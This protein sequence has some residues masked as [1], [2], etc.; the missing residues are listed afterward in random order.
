MANPDASRNAAHRRYARAAE[1]ASAAGANTQG[2]LNEAYKQLYIN[3]DWTPE[4]GWAS[5]YQEGPVASITDASRQYM[6]PEYQEVYQPAPEPVIHVQ[7]KPTVYQPMQGES[8]YDLQV[9]APRILV[10]K[11][12]IPDLEAPNASLTPDQEEDKVNLTAADQKSVVVDES[13]RTPLEQAMLDNGTILENNRSLNPSVD[14]LNELRQQA[15]EIGDNY[16]GS[17]E[18]LANIQR[19]YQEWQND[20]DERLKQNNLPAGLEAEIQRRMT[21]MEDGSELT[22]PLDWNLLGFTSQQQTPSAVRDLYDFY[23]RQE[24]QARGTEQPSFT[25]G[26]AMRA[27][28]W[29]RNIPNESIRNAVKDFYNKPVVDENAIDDGRSPNSREA[30]MMTGDQYLKYRE[31]FGLPG[32]DVDEISPNELYNKQTEQ[33]QYGFIPYLTSEES[34]NR[35]HDAA[36]PMAVSNIFNNLADLR[37]ANTDF[38][39]DYN[40]EQYSGKDFAKNV[41][42]WDQRNSGKK[43]EL[44]YTQEEAGEYGIPQAIVAYGDDGTE[45]V[46]P[47]NPINVV[48]EEDGRIRVIFNDNPEDDWVF[49]NQKDFEENKGTRPAADGEFVGAW[50]KQEPLVLDSGQVLRADQAADLWA[51]QEKYAN[52]GFLDWFKPN[53]ENPFEEGG[54]AP[55]IAD[56][57]LSSA[58]YF[59]LPASGAKAAADAMNNVQGFLPGSQDYINNTYS[60]LSENPTR[61]QQFA[62]TMGSA[63]MPLTERLWGPLGN[64]ALA[65]DPARRIASSVLRIPE[66]ILEKPAARWAT[67]AVNEGLEEIPGNLV[68][69]FQRNGFT[70]WYSDKLYLDQNKQLT[71]S[72]THLDE[73]GEEVDNYPAVDAQGRQLYAPTSFLGRIGNAGEDVPLAFTGGAV[74]GGGIGTLSLPEYGREY[75]EAMRERNE[76]GYNGSD[77]VDLD[78]LMRANEFSD[79]QRRYYNAPSR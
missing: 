53:V 71:T 21:N 2:A 6:T 51:N 4:E 1:V 9:D 68:E 77:T 46:A 56:M 22:N 42:L 69:E 48:E 40:G 62:S 30:L 33:E 15:K 55:W 54:W 7:E 66:R 72:P 23:F 60:L 45:Y 61:E 75:R 13:K 73:N 35:F 5:D 11:D 38:T 59:Y 14:K 41:R 39:L 29:M 27:P 31:Q 34:L 8:N 37:R 32:R 76:L 3:T 10:S 78:A 74:L 12:S 28:D 47:N 20:W 26:N 70:D 49:D 57:A 18:Q 36:A 50:L 19:R 17:Q 16:Q 58:P 24:D 67:G 44:V 63:V 25:P 64:M 43:G 52:Y 79:F 65:G